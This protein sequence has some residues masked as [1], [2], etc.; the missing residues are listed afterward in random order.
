V[1]T[2][3]VLEYEN[4]DG[5]YSCILVKI[6]NSNNY[7]IRNDLIKSLKSSNYITILKYNYHW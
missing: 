7:M 6:S 2:Y 4:K 5:S 1:V 3:K